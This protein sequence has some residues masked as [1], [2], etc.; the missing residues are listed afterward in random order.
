MPRI[1]AGI[2]FQGAPPLEKSSSNRRNRA[3][4]R[5]TDQPGGTGLCLPARPVRA[6]CRVSHATSES[7]DGG[8]ARKTVRISGVL[9]ARMG[10]EIGHRR[11]TTIAILSGAPV[12]NGGI[13]NLRIFP[14]VVTGGQFAFFVHER[15]ES[16]GIRNGAPAREGRRAVLVLDLEVEIPFLVGQDIGRLRARLLIVRSAGARPPPIASMILGD[17]RQA[18]R[19]SARAVRKLAE[20][21]RCYQISVPRCASTCGF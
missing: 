2:P 18:A 5:R 11:R 7:G 19:G 12:P 8:L 20:V 13:S 4:Q 14:V 1:L 16:E 17:N 10:P 3:K 15:P 9:R 21:K 6:D